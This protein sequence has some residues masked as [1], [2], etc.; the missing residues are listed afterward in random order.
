[1]KLISL[2]YAWQYT[3]KFFVLEY[4]LQRDL[5][6]WTRENV[7]RDTTVA[8][9]A[10]KEKLMLPNKYQEGIVSVPE[11][12]NTFKE[13][14]GVKNHVNKACQKLSRLTLNNDVTGA[15][16]Q[17]LVDELNRQL[18]TTLVHDDKV[19]A[20]RMKRKEALS[21]NG[22]LM[23]PK[24]FDGSI[25]KFPLRGNKEPQITLQ[26]AIYLSKVFSR[27]LKIYLRFT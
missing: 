2:S 22:N 25:M 11:T 7:E 15:L 12:P 9:S 20:S 21:L 6:E 16:C 23:D 24:K 1:M 18:Q 27:G 19:T 4:Q 13:L 14:R 8:M 3:F 17:I 26:Q 10:N 5:K